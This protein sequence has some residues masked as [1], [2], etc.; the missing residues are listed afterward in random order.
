MGEERHLREELAERMAETPFYA[1]IG[2]SLVSAAEGEVEV[3]MQVEPRHLNLQGLAHGGIIATL[4]DTAAGLAVRTEL[5]PGRRHV[6]AQ[7]NV[8]Y[9]A[10]ARAG[11]IVARGR[12]VKIG[13]TVAFAEAEVTD[14]RGRVLARTSSVHS[15]MRER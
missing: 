2:F 5:G 1:W 4:A 15:V 14:E 7:L 10:P 3:A 12:T 11:R 13:T 8:D 9:L 6:T